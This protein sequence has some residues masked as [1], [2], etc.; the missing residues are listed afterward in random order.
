MAEAP[1][2]GEEIATQIGTLIT[3]L[4]AGVG[5]MTEGGS[6]DAK[7]AAAALA[8]LAKNAANQVAIAEAGG[9]A[10]LVEL[11]RGGSSRAKESAAGAR[12]PRPVVRDDG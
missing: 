6:A 3:S 5:A 11:A 1:Q 9:I 10:P 12:L 2:I 7:N 8:R 4:S